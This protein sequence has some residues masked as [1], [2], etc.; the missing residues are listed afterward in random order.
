MSDLI[1]LGD[2]NDAANFRAGMSVTR[3]YSSSG[4]GR[5]WRLRAFALRCTQ[6]FRPRSVVTAIDERAGT[7]TLERQRWSWRRWRWE[8]VEP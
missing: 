2:P 1:T 4:L 7:I 5:F 6:W 3:S 8:R